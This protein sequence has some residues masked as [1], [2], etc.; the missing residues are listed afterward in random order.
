MKSESESRSVVSNC[1][2]FAT[3]GLYSPWDSPG[4]NTGVGSC[5]LLQGIF[6]TKG[7]N[8]GLLQCR[9]ILYELSYQGCLS[10]TWTSHISRVACDSYIRE[11]KSRMEKVVFE[12]GQKV[13]VRSMLGYIEV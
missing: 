7:W 6:P 13:L 5:C 1:V 8:P 12:A 10:L 4:Q 3:P 2:Q 9:W 11:H